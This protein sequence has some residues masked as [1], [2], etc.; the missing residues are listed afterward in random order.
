[1]MKP[2]SGGVMAAPKREPACWKPW[3]KARW[4]AGSHRTSAREAAGNAAA[5]PMPKNRR[6]V[7]SET[8]LNAAPVIAVKADHHAMAPPRTIRGP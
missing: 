4:R 8:A 6:A 1:M 5:S 7:A 3:P 2:T